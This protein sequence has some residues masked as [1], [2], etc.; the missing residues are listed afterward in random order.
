MSHI[1]TRFARPQLSTFGPAF[2]SLQHRCSCT[3][4]HILFQSQ[5]RL[6]FSWRQSEPI[7]CK[8]S[9][10]ALLQ[11]Q[12]S[13]VATAARSKVAS[14]CPK[15]TRVTSIAHQSRGSR[16]TRLLAVETKTVQAPAVSSVHGV[17]KH[18]YLATPPNTLQRFLT[19]YEARALCCDP[20]WLPRRS[21]WA[22]TATPAG[23]L[24]LTFC[25]DMCCLK[26]YYTGP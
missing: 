6:L 21:L 12:P 7:P 24:P 8:K 16:P 26:L 25:H 2:C 15:L 5:S 13:R 19:R 14:T 9:I 1:L 10:M 11:L 17:G 3:S 18:I 22:A 20:C 23:H 4:Q